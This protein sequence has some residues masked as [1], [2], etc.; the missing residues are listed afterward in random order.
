[1]PAITDSILQIFKYCLHGVFMASAVTV[2]GLMYTYYLRSMHENGAAKATV[3]NFAVNYVGS[4]IFGALI[5]NEK[6]TIRLLGGVFLILLG[7]S[8]ISTC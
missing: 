6:V 7:T 5:F 4:I 8:L 3:Y 2:S 1:M